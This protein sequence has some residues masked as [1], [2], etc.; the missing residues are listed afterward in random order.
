[1]SGLIEGGW[2][3]RGVRV[4]PPAL[5]PGR[6]PFLAYGWLTDA[7]GKFHAASGPHYDR[8]RSL[9]EGSI[10]TCFSKHSGQMPWLKLLPVWWAM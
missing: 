9:S 10:R 6:T 8:V 3:Q 4:S 1:M 2:S 5:H 7:T